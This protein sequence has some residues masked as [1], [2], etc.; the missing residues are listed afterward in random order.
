MPSF[1]RR[2]F[3]SS[4][5]PQSTEAEER[6]S[7]SDSDPSELIAG[8][9]HYVAGKAGNNKD[10]SY[11]DAS[12]AP[13]EESSPLGYDVGPLTILFLNVS[14][15]IGTG[16]FSTPSS[17][18]AG[19]GSIGL[20]L[21]W[22]ALG[23]LTSITAFAVYLE[24]TAYFPSRSGAEVVYLEQAFP[25]PRWLFSTAFAF[26]SVI[27]S[28]SSAN[29]YVLAQYLFKMTDHS[30]TDWQLKGVAIAGYSVA[31]LGFVVLGGHTRVQ[32]PTANFHN[33]FEGKATAYGIT[34]GL[35]K[36]IFS[37]AG[38][39]N[40]FNVVN[41]VKNPVKQIRRNGYIAI[42][43]VSILYILTVIAYYSAVPKQD[44]ING[45]LT[46]ANLFF[47]N[48]FGD[49]KRV[50]ALNFLIAISAFGNLVAV[51]IG[52]SRIIREC[53]RQGV[54]PWTKFWVSTYPL[55]TALGPYLFKYAI[56]LVMILAPPAGDAFNFVSDLRIYPGSFF[57]FLMSVGLLVVRHRR[58]ALNLPRP[59]FKAWDIVIWFSILKNL[60]LLVMPWYP[61]AGGATGGD[62]SFWY[63]TYVVAS[64]GIL[65]ACVAYYWLWIHG[66][67][68][69][70]GYTIREEVIT[71]DDGSKSHQL[72][73]V[74]N[75]DLEE[76]DKTHD[77]AGRII[78]EAAESSA[79][80][81]SNVLIS[82]K[83]DTVSNI[84]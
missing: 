34:N 43:T 71:L 84:K 47:V 77:H 3:R 27:L 19:T 13:V 33:S 51:F 83:E 65:L 52:T 31:L 57:D 25:R 53:G 73:K 11:Q 46:V 37:Y 74:P 28:F 72:I 2:P 29:S 1:W 23:F 82:G 9:T 54:L 6:G 7:T 15:M 5:E 30:P 62:V 59:E 45:K 39:E 12:G 16:I 22:W 50:R 61:P 68:Y 32:D 40:A 79:K 38:F 36:I 64:I 67:P 75:A 44:I 60:Y 42:W 14:K 69:F 41:E 80:T 10:V 78:T 56:T 49:S 70:R 17:I 26:Q 55:G 4:E 24:F 76:W 8:D 63:A 21:I 18:L 81:S 20:S 35:Y 48:V 66:I 58:K